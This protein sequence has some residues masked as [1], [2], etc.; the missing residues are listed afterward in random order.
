MPRKCKHSRGWLLIGMVWLILV[1]C[2]THNPTQG[3]K[4]TT[5][6]KVFLA[7]KN[8]LD[9]PTNIQINQN[10]TIGEYFGYMDSLVRRY[11]T[12]VPYPLSEHLLARN[13]PWV[14]DTLANTDYYRM[15]ERDSFVYDQ[16]KMIVLPKGSILQFPDSLKACTILRNFERTEIDVNIP[17]YTLR[18]F[19]DSILLY[20]FPVRV[21]QN[22]KRYLAMGDRETDLR[23][24]RGK[25][26]I[27]KH[28]K[29][30]DFYNP[31]DG[32]QFFL[33]KRDDGQTTLMPQIPWIE[34][35]INGVRNGQMIHPTTNPETLG[36]AY[37]NGCIGTKEADAW[38]IYYYAPLGT[39]IRIRYDLQ[40]F[41]EGIVVSIFKDVYGYGI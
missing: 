14:I 18:I 29:H 8:K 21:G 28:V 25:G 33:T 12:L 40:N 1:S 20:T 32:K 17:E 31:V 41:E 5:N 36:K 9:L 4:M 3:E 27:V 13:N 11:D 37:S 39:G 10:V 30:P 26:T 15:I 7:D 19:Q 16:R 22:R 23:T 6:I 35:Q 24:K 38:V 34:T 2:N